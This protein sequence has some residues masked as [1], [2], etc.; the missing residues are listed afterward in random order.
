MAVPEYDEFGMLSDNCEEHGLPW[1]GAPVVCRESIQLSDGRLLSALRW[2]WPAAPELVLL[3]GG[4]QNAH[5]WDTVA[6]VLSPRPLLAIDLPS[7][8]HSDAARDFVHDPAGLARDV[9]EVIAK[10]A[11]S[12]K[13]VCGLSLGGL[14]SIVL[15]T[16]QPELVRK[17]VLVDV[18]P[19]ITTKRGPA[20]GEAAS[21]PKCF[22]SFDA[23]LAHARARHPTRSEAAL[24]R[25]CLHD[26]VSTSDGSWIWRWLVLPP[27]ALP[28]A[29]VPRPRASPS[30]FCL[31]L[32]PRPR[33]SP[34]CL[35]LASNLDA[36][37][38]QAGA[39]IRAAIRGG[40]PSRSC[41]AS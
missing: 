40:R 36:A 22:A 38:P 24:R 2:G 17:L 5:S 11:P 31:A 28:L 23:L 20:T 4:A 12:A 35:A 25:D 7:H 15:A 39:A 1:K 29:L 26:A 34:S 30:P 14:V 3:H 19:G 8:G 41:G 16:T 18:T 21:A 27:P 13:V 10:T 9:G 33:A 6:L 37:L 32:M